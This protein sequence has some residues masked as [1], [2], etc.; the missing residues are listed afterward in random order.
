[1]SKDITVASTTDTQEEVNLAAGIIP[2]KNEDET[3]EPP[4]I[5]PEGEEPPEEVESKDQSGAEGKAETGA[6]PGAESETAQPQKAEADTKGKDTG[7]GGFTK[8]IDVL[9]KRNAILEERL[10]ALADRHEELMARLSAGPSPEVGAGKTPITVAE[11]GLQLP[12]KPTPDQFLSKGQTYE[13]YLE[14]LTDWKIQVKDVQAEQARTAESRKAEEV[15]T[16]ETFANHNRRMN[17]AS[18]RYDDF[19][20]VARQDISIPRAVGLAIVELENG[21]DIVYYLGK[22][23]DICEELMGM[24]DL[25]AIA[26]IGAIAASLV[27]ANGGESNTQAKTPVSSSAPAPIRP[28]GGTST[29]SSVPLDET[30]YQTYRR[31]R[32]EQEKARYRT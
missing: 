13:D 25:A 18:E 5:S 21:P 16:A 9:T 31:V 22:N 6:K 14:A 2:D 23:P 30:D 19:E 10:T 4:E 29:K 17:E 32:A 20:E 24:S 7:K 28:G 15:R 12:P 11:A 8:R 3:P 26:E 27:V 1:M